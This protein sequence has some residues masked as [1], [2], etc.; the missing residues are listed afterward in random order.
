ME[1][2][3][4]ELLKLPKWAVLRIQKLE[5]EK[6]ALDARLD[7]ATGVTVTKVF[8]RLDWAF[9]NPKKVY[10]DSTREVVFE[11]PGNHRA[12]EV[13]QASE[14]N[15]TSYGPHIRVTGSMDSLLIA[16]ECSNVVR[17]SLA[18]I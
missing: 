18:R 17:I 1:F 12:I 15:V 7:I 9:E 13:R 6:A 2:S 4:I 10:L 8:Q 11:Q 3:P 14:E 16:P 5:N